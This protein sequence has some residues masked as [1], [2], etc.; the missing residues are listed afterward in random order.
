MASL[1]S[2]I[3]LLT[4][5]DVGNSWGWNHGC[6]SAS[7]SAPREDTV[8]LYHCREGHC[9]GQ[10]AVTEVLPG[11]TLNWFAGPLGS[12]QPV[13]GPRLYC[14]HMGRAFLHTSYCQSLFFL[15][16]KIRLLCVALAV[17]ELISN[18]EIR[19]PP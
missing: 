17:Q 15:L 7:L 5:N 18:L 4:A 9:L 10:G 1:L 3:A 11:R 6:R 19:L 13:R 2:F 14:Y 8:L 16:F 12:Q